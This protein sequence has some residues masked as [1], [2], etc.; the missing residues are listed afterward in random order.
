[1]TIFDSTRI[2]TLLEQYNPWWKTG[3][4]SEHLP[5]MHRKTYHEVLHTISNA[6][7][8][9]FAV[10][11]G[12]RRVGK[13]TVM[14]QLIVE[15]LSQGVS[16]GNILYLT[17]DNPIFKLCG[18]DQVIQAY[19]EHVPHQGIYYFF[20]DEVQYA[21]SW[22]LWVKTLYDMHQN[23]RLVATG[24]ASPAIEKGASDSGVGRWRVFRMPTMTFNEF[25]YMQG[26]EASNAPLPGLLEIAQ[27]GAKDFN[28]LML[29][30]NNLSPYWNR[31]LQIGGF[32]EL[33]QVKD[34][35]EAQ[36]VL[37][38]DVVD[39]V[40]K[41]DVPALFDVRNA[42]QLEKIFLY[43]CL[44]TGN[45]T[46]YTSICSELEGVSKPTLARYIDYLRDA[47]LLYLSHDN[48]SI[49]KRGLAARPKI[50]IADAALRN[51]CLMIENPLINPADLGIMVETTI[52]KHFVCAFSSRAH[53]GYMRMSADKEIDI[54]VSL[55][56]GEKLLCEVKYRT[57]S[58]ITSQ[59]AILSQS[60]DKKCIGAFV[61]SKDAHDYGITTT[62]SGSRIIRI[63][64]PTLCYLLGAS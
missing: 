63:P 14:K 3:Q 44:H 30:F 55:P 37:R 21:D 20:L 31:Y 43:L 38:E 60:T 11:S 57:H 51:A 10:L 1:M 41:R 7:L 24:S 54:V 61:A 62:E 8:R 17:F 18:I 36:R 28:H 19:E 42:L 32:P 45:L 23:L 48:H 13:T 34:T 52:F 27:M 58:P 56:A 25:C 59:D 29:Q 6:E 4:V 9:R 39:K 16:P 15:L 2:Y 40:L 22:S 12:A 35:A 64:A 46:S 50:Y 49:G 33:M 53:V 5:P 26:I 47:N